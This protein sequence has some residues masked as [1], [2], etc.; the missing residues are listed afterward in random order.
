MIKV[1]AMQGLFQYSFI[2]I[3]G[4]CVSIQTTKP[5]TMLKKIF[6]VLAVIFSL[7]TAQQ[8]FGQ[9]LLSELP[10]TKGE[11]IKSEPKVLATIDWLETTPFDKEEKK[12]LTQKTLLVTWI[13]NSPTVTLEVNANILTFTK[14]NPDLLITFM[15][16]WTK[17]CLQNSYSTDNVKGSLAGVKSAIKVYKS[18]SLKKDKEMDK[19]VEMETKGELENWVTTMMKKK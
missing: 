17:Y 14:K 8:S 2:H 15:G 1:P 9:E 11:F 12:R 4:R 3:F 7:A 18:L 19:L 13:T 6:P 16:G 5:Y 10:T